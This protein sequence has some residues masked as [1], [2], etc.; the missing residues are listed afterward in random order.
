MRALRLPRPAQWALIPILIVCAAAT[1]ADLPTPPGQPAFGPGGSAYPFGDI[2]MHRY[3]EAAAQYWIFEPSKPTPKTAPVI[4]FCHGWGAFSPNPY[5]AWIRHLVRRGNIVIYPRYQA[6]LFAPMR[7]YT[8]N[9]IT[10]VRAALAEL[11]SGP[12][13]RPE[14]DHLAIVGHSMGGAI[15]PNLAAQA[16][17]QGL[18]IPKALCCLE[19]DNHPGWAPGV[20][21]P[22]ADFS[23]IRSGT[24]V[25]VIVGDKD[26]LARD[27]TARLIYSR[28]GQ[29][30]PA[31][32]DYV[33][34]VS[35]DHGSPPL[36][37]N[38]RVPVAT[39]VL[40]PDAALYEA[41]LQPRLRQG[42]EG[43]GADALDFYGTW[44][45]FDALTDA[46][47]YRKNRRYAL[48]D[49]P[50]QRFMGKWSDG[51][52]VNELKIGYPN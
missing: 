45:L 28:L 36:V 2:V 41:P 50:E 34:L 14:L 26:R 24:L 16:V 6:V 47:F 37:A 22:A 49:T 13:V 33:T 7:Q 52:P 5:G 21:M 29:I 4:V 31:D 20:Q 43:D 15:V 35:D 8:P 48:G 25:L 3:G 12:H 38:H 51:R 18:P 30:P 1:S 46:A 23:F 44:K 19:P 42:M 32:K 40:D 11:Q 10:A 17:A 27:D 39:V 9:T